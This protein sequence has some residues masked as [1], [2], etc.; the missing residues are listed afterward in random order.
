MISSLEE[1]V[2]DDKDAM[3]DWFDWCQLLLRDMAVFKAT[4]NTALLIN[5]D[6]AEEI[7]ATSRGAG[8]RDILKLA[9]ELYN[10][11]RKLTFNLN[12]QLTFNMVRLLLRTNL[13]QGKE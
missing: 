11:K 1:E 2:W 5:Q 9:R 3:E 6:K 8:L 13:G 10:I 7:K 4:G 12:K